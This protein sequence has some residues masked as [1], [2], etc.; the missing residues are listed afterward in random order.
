MTP[1]NETWLANIGWK[2]GS[3]NEQNPSGNLPWN[4]WTPAGN[5]TQPVNLTILSDNIAAIQF[6]VRDPTGLNGQNFAAKF[7]IAR[8]LLS[9]NYNTQAIS[10]IYPVSGSYDFLTR[11]LFYFL[12]FFALL[13]RRHT[14]V[15]VAAL[16]TAMTYSATTA[17]HALALLTQFGWTDSP[18]NVQSSKAHGDPDIQGTYPILLAAVVMFTPI[19]NWS[20]NVRRD[21]AQ[22][23]MFA[24]GMLSFAALVPVMV[25]LSSTRGG[26]MLHPWNTNNLASLMLCPRD[27]V[28]VNPICTP[29]INVT[30]EN[31][32]AC[33]CFDFCGLL[34]P[35]APMRSGAKMVAWL[36]TRVSVESWNIKAFSTFQYWSTVLAAIIVCYGGL[37]LIHSHFSLREMRNILFRCCYTRPKECGV[38][39]K[40][41]RTKN[42]TPKLPDDSSEDASTGLRKAQFMFARSVAT[43]YFLLGTLVATVSPA[44]FVAVIVN[45]EVV[46]MGQFTYSE[47]NDAIGAWSTWVGAALVLL[48]AIILQYQDA[49]ER[50]LLRSGKRMLYLLG[51]EGLEL[52]KSETTT[53]STKKSANVISHFLRCS[54]G[55]AFVTL[56][57][58]CT[59]FR[60]WLKAPP[61]H[62]QICSCENCITYRNLIRNN[63]TIANHAASCSCND[64]SAY[65]K[66]ID[67]ASEYHKQLCGCP[68][69]DSSRQQA[70]CRRQQEKRR[71]CSYCLKEDDAADKGAI[72]P[73]KI[74]D[75]IKEKGYQTLG[76]RILN[77]FDMRVIDMLK[78]PDTLPT[79]LP[80]AHLLKKFPAVGIT[81][82]ALDY[83]SVAKPADSN[84]L[85]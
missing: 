76:M 34:G 22:I 15:A 84:K 64:C 24:W 19:L 57:M 26:H 36:P 72:G 27:A 9:D 52:R 47:G 80:S 60:D 65:K 81:P 20:T 82:I 67:K 3:L 16:G 23:I 1:A 74:V 41:S 6:L 14:W 51:F 29:P 31:Y 66:D 48:V 70:H 53:K 32:A 59:E 77:K 75:T 37:G 13:Y 11:L 21:K 79:T 71:S 61:P 17:V 30:A 55:G 49:W 54:I 40:L 58:A 33:E 85:Q 46:V 18:S 5:S 45:M 28:K 25:Y 39:W 7:A 12:L 10:C 50:F 56:Q 68:L 43:V 38:L 73:M 78:V 2:N 8:T 69:C 42:I 44:I 62:S 35:T 4:E 63:S 83:T